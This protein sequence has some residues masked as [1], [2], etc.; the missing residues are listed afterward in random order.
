MP[1]AKKERG[2]PPTKYPM[3]DKIDADPETIAEVVL[4]AKPKEVW[5]YEQEQPRKGNGQFE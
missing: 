1:K 4:K 5:Q 2:R 3:P